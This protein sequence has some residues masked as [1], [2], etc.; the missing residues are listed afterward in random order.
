MTLVHGDAYF[1]NYLCPKGS[2]AGTTYLL[3]WQSYAFDIG[4]YDLVNMC[5]TFWTSQQRNEEQR[6]LTILRRYHAL[7]QSYN[8]R[9][10]SW[11]DLLTDYKIGLIYWLL[12]PVQDCYGGSEKDYWWPK[13]QC[14][15]T[16]FRE[17]HCEDLLSTTMN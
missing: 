1:A 3:D 17:W 4:A 15:V 8:I 12:M 7:L 10:Y 5:A 13:M 16:A 9:D 11:D 2:S 14:L 6:E